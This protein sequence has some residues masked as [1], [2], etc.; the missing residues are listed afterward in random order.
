VKFRAAVAFVALLT[1]APV[2]AWS[3]D[4]GSFR[5]WFLATTL[6]S[7][8]A[9]ALVAWRATD[10]RA[11]LA[12]GAAGGLLGTIGYDVVRVPFSLAG[13]RLFA[14]I[15]SYG[16]LLTG[17]HSSRP[18]TAFAGWCYHLANGVGFGVAYG[19]LMRGRNRWWGVVWGLTLETGTVVTPFVSLYGL[20]GHPDLIAVAYGAHVF[21]GLPLGYA[22]E[23][24]L[25]LPATRA[26]GV[27]VLAL[28]VWLRPWSVPAPTRDG[29]RVAPGPSAVV[30]DGRF[31]P[32]WLRV[33]QGQCVAIRN[34]DDVAYDLP[35][36]HATLTPG[37]TTRVCF[38]ARGVLR[39]R[40]S[41]EPYSGGFVI[42]ERSRR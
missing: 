41:P 20:R 29:E 22:V 32:G 23:R 1:V 5:A 38:D 3:Y 35:K 6:P 16:V 25:A 26:L 17:A 2:L 27:A 13:V 11:L 24:G 9:L 36:Q 34:D 18:L 7:V 42:V 21:Y 8:V 33:T 30:R 37:A 19:V 40:T 15:E 28:A 14:P 31:R 12:T 39:V 10:L 4:L